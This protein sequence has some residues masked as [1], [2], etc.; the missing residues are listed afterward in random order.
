MKRFSIA[1]ININGFFASKI[2][3]RNATFKN[4]R[5]EFFTRLKKVPSRCGMLILLPAAD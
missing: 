3:G 2:E 1:E 5:G 4:A